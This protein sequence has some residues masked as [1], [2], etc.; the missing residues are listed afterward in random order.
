MKESKKW[1]SASVNSVDNRYIGYELTTE[2]RFAPGI[3]DDEKRKMLQALS[4]GHNVLS[5]ELSGI[6]AAYNDRPIQVAEPLIG[7]VC[8]PE[9]RKTCESEDNRQLTPTPG[10]IKIVEELSKKM[11]DPKIEK[12]KEE[13]I[14]GLKKF[15]SVS[16]SPISMR[17]TAAND[18]LKVAEKSLI[19]LFERDLEIRDQKIKKML[20][21][22]RTGRKSLPKKI[23]GMTFNEV[24]KEFGESHRPLTDSDDIKPD[25]KKT[26][27]VKKSK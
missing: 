2:I 1:A 21:A 15:L 22:R 10:N 18:I 6:Q 4:C 12:S 19:S 8:P 23:K 7:K 17:T 13:V 24:Q 20:D 25:T 3:P 26:R 9:N 11:A 27:K 16:K 5:A 14:A